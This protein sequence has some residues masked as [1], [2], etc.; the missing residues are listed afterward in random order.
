LFQYLIQLLRFM[1]PERSLDRALN[2]SI[3]TLLQDVTDRKPVDQLSNLRFSER[4]ILHGSASGYTPHPGDMVATEFRG[5]WA[6]SSHLL[7]L[8]P[9]SRRLAKS[10]TES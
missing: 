2:V 5:I 9:L 4:G 7:I 6:A 1:H 8:T 3:G 10:S